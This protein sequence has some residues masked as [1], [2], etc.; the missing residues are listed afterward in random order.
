M[1]LRNDPNMRKRPPKLL[2]VYGKAKWSLC[3]RGTARLAHLVNRQERQVIAG[4]SGGVREEDQ[5]R[6]I[7][8]ETA[9]QTHLVKRQNTQVI[10]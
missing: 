2:Q 10:A 6:G 3:S 4:T 5:L 8:E 9:T 7:I 1:E